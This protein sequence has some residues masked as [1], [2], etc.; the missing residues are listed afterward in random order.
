[1]TTPAPIHTIDLIRKKRDGGA[2]DAR[3]LA[4]LVTGAAS[5]AIPPRAALRLA[6]GRLAARPLAR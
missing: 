4:F 3:E 1:M 6:H 2:L 5:G